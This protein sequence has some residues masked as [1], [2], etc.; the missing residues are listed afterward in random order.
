MK[1]GYYQILHVEDDE[2]LAS[3]YGHMVHDVLHGQGLLHEITWVD[4]IDTAYRV[5]GESWRELD[6]RWTMPM[7]AM[8]FPWCK[9]CGKAPGKV[10]RFLWCQPMWKFIRKLWTS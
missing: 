8:G 7:A 4:A 10:F 5:I 2:R 3:N 1:N 6:F 9:C